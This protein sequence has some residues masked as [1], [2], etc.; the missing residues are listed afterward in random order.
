MLVE[1]Y[2]KKKRDLIMEDIKSYTAYA[3]RLLERGIERDLLEGRFEVTN[4]YD[5]RVS[6]RDYYKG[7]DAE[8]SLKGGKVFCELDRSRDCDHVG[9]VLSDPVI[10]KRAKQLGVKLRHKS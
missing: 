7:K 4:R 5:D 8:V 6:V 2:E 10:L 1:A 3:Q 9:F